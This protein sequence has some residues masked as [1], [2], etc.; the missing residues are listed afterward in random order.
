MATTPEY[1]NYKERSKH[2]K[3]VPSKTKMTPEHY[4][5]LSRLD[6]GDAKILDLVC[7]YVSTKEMWGWLRAV[8]LGPGLAG[9]HIVLYHDWFDVNS[10]PVLHQNV[11]Y[12]AIRMLGKKDQAGADVVGLIRTF[13]KMSDNNQ[14]F[15][16]VRSPVG[17]LSSGISTEALQ[18]S[19]VA[20]LEKLTLPGP[21]AEK[22]EKE[23][24]LGG[25]DDTIFPL[26]DGKLRDGGGEQGGEEDGGAMNG[27]FYN[28]YNRDY[29]DYRRDQDRQQ[30]QEMEM[31]AEK[32]ESPRGVRWGEEEG[33]EE[34]D[35]RQGEEEEEEME[36]GQQME[37]EGEEEMEEEEEEM[38]E[39]DENGEEFELGETT[40][41]AEDEVLK[42][43]GQSDIEWYDP[44]AVFYQYAADN[45]RHARGM[46]LNRGDFVYIIPENRL[47]VADY[48]GYLRDLERFDDK[49]SG[50]KTSRIPKQFE[51]FT[52]FYPGYH[53]Y[54]E[55]VGNTNPTRNDVAFVVPVPVQKL[56]LDR[57]P[58]RGKYH[59]SIIDDQ[60]LLV[61]PNNMPFTETIYMRFM[62]LMDEYGKPANG[63]DP[64]M[65]SDRMARE[66]LNDIV[67][68]QYLK[69][70]IFPRHKK[71]TTMLIKGWN[72]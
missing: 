70:E 7:V 43:A 3:Y 54:L 39:E 26:S 46:T 31:E 29:E 51:A 53:F 11:K 47:L 4:L 65:Y 63:G 68:F 59:Y 23:N 69:S 34:D 37:E 72:E 28:I 35:R 9:Q 18:G 12:G 45:I 67:F 56:S 49:L 62:Q 33:E 60:F 24:E 61:Y 27:W 38:E 2:E 19:R 58:G 25:T 32:K 64:I 10:C 40:M 14:I 16:G 66:V 21:P 71:L 44:N 36:D 1:N 30:A 8:Y 15:I 48:D 57:N 17:M 50:R 41:V 22:K 52:Q 20:P 5:R 13:N 6:V 55:G 42:T